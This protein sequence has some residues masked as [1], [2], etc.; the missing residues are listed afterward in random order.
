MSDI[1]ETLEVRLIKY[2]DFCG[3][4]SNKV[5]ILIEGQRAHICNE[6]VPVCVAVVEQHS[7]GVTPRKRGGFGSGK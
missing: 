7:Q 6:C 3:K 5:K 2:C 1:I 4:S